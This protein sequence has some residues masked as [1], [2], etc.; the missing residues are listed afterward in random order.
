MAQ[1]GNINTNRI[2]TVSSAP[3]GVEKKQPDIASRTVSFQTNVNEQAVRTSIVNLSDDAIVMSFN[4]AT[5]VNDKL[6]HA[7]YLMNSKHSEIANAY[8]TELA[9][10]AEGKEALIAFVSDMVT[11]KKAIYP[12]RVLGSSFQVEEL[13]SIVMKEVENNQRNGSKGIENS[14]LVSLSAVPA[15]ISSVTNRKELTLTML[16]LVKSS[17]LEQLDKKQETIIDKYLDKLA[18]GER[19]SDKEVDDVVKQALASLEKEPF[20]TSCKLIKN[21]FQNYLDK[22]KKFDNFAAIVRDTLGKDSLKDVSDFE[23]VDVALKTIL[24][25]YGLYDNES[26]NK[27]INEAVGAL[28]EKG[29]VHISYSQS[30]P[31]NKMYSFLDSAIN[32]EKT[33]M[34]IPVVNQFRSA[35]KISAEKLVDSVYK[36]VV[37]KLFSNEYKEVVNVDG[38]LLLQNNSQHQ[39]IAIIDQVTALSILIDLRAS[40]KLD[41]VQN[42]EVDGLIDKLLLGIGLMHDNTKIFSGSRYFFDGVLRTREAKDKNSATDANLL[43]TKA[44]LSLHSL[45]GGSKYL[46]SAKKYM[47]EIRVHGFANI[48]DGKTQR[49][50]VKVSPDIQDLDDSRTFGFNSSGLVFESLLSFMQ[51]DKKNAGFW[52]KA[53]QDNFH[54]MSELLKKGL[55]KD[56]V[57]LKDVSFIRFDDGNLNEYDTFNKF[58]PIINGV[59]YGYI[60]SVMSLYKHDSQNEF[61]LIDESQYKEFFKLLD[62]HSQ[63][64][65][66]F[67]LS[68]SNELVNMVFYMGNKGDIASDTKLPEGSSIISGDKEVRLF[69]SLRFSYNK[70]LLGMDHKVDEKLEF[71]SS[72]DYSFKYRPDLFRSYSENI[73][74]ITALLRED[75]T[76]VRKLAVNIHELFHNF[77]RFDKGLCSDLLNSL[78]GKNKL[79]AILEQLSDSGV[80]SFDSNVAA[81]SKYVELAKALINELDNDSYKDLRENIERN[82]FLDV[83]QADELAASWTGSKP[84]GML[85]AI[86]ALNRDLSKV[87]TKQINTYGNDAVLRRLKLIVA[88]GSP[89]YKIHPVVERSLFT[90][91][92][93]LDIQQLE[94]TISM[95][96][97]GYSSL[98]RYLEYVQRLENISGKLKDQGLMKNYF[99]VMNAYV[100]AV[101]NIA[102]QD[103][104]SEQR[105]SY[106]R[107]SI[108]IGINTLKEITGSVGNDNDK[109]TQE[110]YRD[111]MAEV[112]RSYAILGEFEVLGSILKDIVGYELSD[113]SIISGRDLLYEPYSFEKFS[114]H[115]NYMISD[116]SNEFMTSSH[117]KNMSGFTSGDDRKQFLFDVLSNIRGCYSRGFYN[118]NITDYVKDVIQKSNAETDNLIAVKSE[119]PYDNI[120]TKAINLIPLVQMQ[121]LKGYDHDSF[122]KSVADI[123][124]QESF[125]SVDVEYSES[126]R[127]LNIDPKDSDEDK[128]IS[129]KQHE[130]NVNKYAGQLQKMIGELDTVLANYNNKADQSKAENTKAVVKK[131]YRGAFS[132]L[133]DLVSGLFRKET[134][135]AAKTAGRE[136]YELFDDKSLSRVNERQYS[137]DVKLTKAKLLF[138]KLY[139]LRS[140]FGNNSET[141]EVLASLK[142]QINELENY[143]YNN[144]TEDSFYYIKKMGID[145]KQLRI[146]LRFEEF[147]I[148]SDK[149]P[150]G[151][152]KVVQ[153]CFDDIAKL[154]ADNSVDKTIAFRHEKNIRSRFYQQIL[155]SMYGFLMA[156]PDAYSDDI[157]YKIEETMQHLISDSV[158]DQH[159]DVWLRGYMQKLLYGLVSKLESQDDL[160]GKD[161]NKLHINEL[162]GLI[163]KIRSIGYSNKDVLDSKFVLNNNSDMNYFEQFYFGKSH[164][165]AAEL[166][167]KLPLIME[168]NSLLKNI[169]SHEFQPHKFFDENDVHLNYLN[170]KDIKLDTSQITNANSIFWNK[171][172]DIVSK[173]DEASAIKF[174]NDFIDIANAGTE[175][176]PLYKLRVA[177]FNS[178]HSL[179][180]HANISSR[181]NMMNLLLEMGLQDVAREVFGNVFIVTPIGKTS[182]ESFSAFSKM[183][184]H[185]INSYVLDQDIVSKIFSIKNRIILDSQEGA[186]DFRLLSVAGRDLVKSLDDFLPALSYS[187]PQNGKNADVVNSLPDAPSPYVFVSEDI[188]LY[189]SSN[190]RYLNYISSIPL[191]TNISATTGS[192]EYDFN[193]QMVA[194]KTSIDTVIKYFGAIEESGESLKELKPIVES[195]ISKINDSGLFSD[196]DRA[197]QMFGFDAY[198]LLLYVKFF[199]KKLELEYDSI[200][201]I[202]SAVDI[203]EV[204]ISKPNDEQLADFREAQF[205]KSL[206]GLTHVQIRSL[207]ANDGVKNDMLAFVLRPDVLPVVSR[208]LYVKLLKSDYFKDSNS[209]IQSG[210]DIS[211]PNNV[212]YELAHNNGIILQVNSLM[213]SKLIQDI[214]DELLV[215]LY[216]DAVMAKLSEV[217]SFTPYISGNALDMQSIN[218][219]LTEIGKT[220]TPLSAYIYMPHVGKGKSR[221]N[222]Q[223]G[224]NVLDYDNFKKETVNKLSD[225]RVCFMPFMFEHNEYKDR[226]NYY[227]VAQIETVL[228][229]KRL[230]ILRENDEQQKQ[231]LTEQSIKLI[232]EYNRLVVNGEFG[233]KPIITRSEK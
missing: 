213:N 56:E 136:V 36:D 16:E 20:S 144:L 162:R 120:G 190:T 158:S 124:L 231:V 5:N 71:P 143:K 78:S 223:V 200:S 14:L 174:V 1:I 2:P 142:T 135:D 13:V 75:S 79:G 25:D 233:R 101:N 197:L 203:S 168:N 83:N 172:K 191:P 39:Q 105:E 228:L 182:R 84:P 125:T 122:F 176:G 229:Q 170:D 183:S 96:E 110:L 47:D 179:N 187:L 141:K 26:Y 11:E 137:F 109:F 46:E 24:N 173:M 50:L 214:D 152:S 38:A 33:L 186:H 147:S 53:I 93:P 164:N 3:T 6:E 202:P 82:L 23:L 32:V 198:K 63:P 132:S 129:K 80:L 10:T 37:E 18:K 100:R 133:K 159:K 175:N 199:S 64:S 180:D 118:P 121:E 19:L 108:S 58:S 74:E 224:Q 52:K 7:V 115:D 89:Y 90:A 188:G 92:Y 76:S 139:L 211:N 192:L 134:L 81:S 98:D 204:L 104:N 167:Q 216:M 149:S 54:V 62:N 222:V 146:A 102:E 95:L 66:K 148:S 128:K 166:K 97:S 21:I 163:S 60:T 107:T 12:H 72:A 73:K 61:G 55:S 35:S 88:T 220:I 161:K 34:D 126:V 111:V 232:D 103:A 113:K 193:K 221:L 230:D 153:A 91:E 210:A 8:L 226:E 57:Y 49:L 157:L 215:A 67:F 94:N 85:K 130:S 138:A 165:E 4:T 117:R 145:V 114:S 9:K 44:Y 40:D 45:R 127:R 86:I 156:N 151:L 217:S 65:E 15:L 184:F 106:L 169:F 68:P 207:L 87:S 155:D 177:L 154:L 31:L 43:L 30:Y 160:N 70:L 112:L 123:A 41:D 227:K 140:T 225:D 99:F 219:R 218:K 195:I 59:N 51:Y 29:I 42:K 69:E 171:I 209:K 22:S 194:C 201:E 119:L 131:E 17:M 116:L 150:E 178:G 27:I 206:K 196:A 28:S 77:S 181:I 48:F 185:P 189:D 208:D 205:L 212:I